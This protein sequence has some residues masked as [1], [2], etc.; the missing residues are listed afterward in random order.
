MWAAAALGKWLA[1]AEFRHA[2]AAYRL[3]P[4]IAIPAVARALPSLESVLAVTLLVPGLQAIGAVTSSGLLAA[5]AM[6][7][8]VNLV[9]H[10][11]EIDCG[12]HPG[13]RQSVSWALVLRN[14]GLAALSLGLLAPQVARPW[15]LADSLVTLL[16]TCF[17]C[18]AWLLVQMISDTHSL[19][20]GAEQ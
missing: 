2:L 4:A 17:T 8:A 11:D 7:M 6:A 13:R 16:A 18:L 15:Q 10:R 19:L 14:T 1:A 9:R 12:C 3:L 5:Y 20:D